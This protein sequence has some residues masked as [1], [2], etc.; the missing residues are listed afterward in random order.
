M[1][2]GLGRLRYE[3]TVASNNDD[4]TYLK[5]LIDSDGVGETLLI[6]DLR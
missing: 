1:L 5:K 6:V 3:V 4:K 2:P